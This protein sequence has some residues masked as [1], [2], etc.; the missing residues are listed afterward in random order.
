MRR[1]TTIL[2][3]SLLFAG[4]GSRQEP[5]GNVPSANSSRPANMTGAVPATTSAAPAP[6]PVATPLPLP[7]PSPS[8]VGACMMQGGQRVSVQRLRA[9]GTE[10]FWSARIEGRCVTYSHPDDQAGTR[11]WTRYTETADGGVWT[12][13][14]GGRRFE[15]RTRQNPGC[16]DGMSDKAYPIA[17]ELQVND[18]RRRGCAE[19]A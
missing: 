11:V 16:S 3:A 6:S 8:A 1:L 18:E 4:C 10:P 9:V 5:A 15:L 2:L 14:L 12:G 19:P 7:L 17:V 13:A